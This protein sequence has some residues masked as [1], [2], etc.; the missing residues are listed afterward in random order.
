MTSRI[1]AVSFG[2]MCW[3]SIGRL[4][5]SVL[6]LDRNQSDLLM[7]AEKGLS[8]HGHTPVVRDWITNTVRRSVR[9]RR[10]RT[11]VC[12]TSCF[13]DRAFGITEWDD[14]EQIEIV[15]DAELR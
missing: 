15:G 8:T 2:T 12:G 13:A 4:P 5:Q 9:G 14:S 1:L 6:A 7:E 3:T 10:L 11:A